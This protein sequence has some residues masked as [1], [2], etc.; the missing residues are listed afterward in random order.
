MADTTQA[1]VN[2]TYAA[3]HAYPSEP[4]SNHAVVNNTNNYQQPQSSAP[5][6]PPANEQKNEISKDEVGWFFVEQ[7]YTT[8]SR[9]PKKLHLFY[10]RRSQFVFGTEAE[11]VPVAVGQKVCISSVCPCLLVLANT[12]VCLLPQAIA[13][14]IKQL[15][16]HDCKVR[17]LNVDTQSSFENILVSVIGEISNGSEPSRKFVQTFVL[18]EQPNGYY[19]LNDIFRYLS[20][21]DEEFIVDETAPAD[22]T[23][24]QQEVPVEATAQ[25]QAEPAE[26]AVQAQTETQAAAPQVD[27]KLEQAAT[28]AAEQAQEPAPQANGTTA[29]EEKPATPAAAPAP[30]VPAVP[31]EPEAAK[32]EKPKSP[33]PT[34]ADAPTK[35][36]TAPAPEKEN[37]QPP[38]PAVPK[39]WANV[40]SNRAGSAQAPVP[41]PV[42]PVAPPKPAPAPSTTTQQ[43]QP[44][45]QPQQA[46]AQAQAQPQPSAAPST[47]P[48]PE[49]APSQPS[50]NDG[51]GWQT[52]GH[53]NKRQSRAGDDQNVFAYIKNVTEKVDAAL[54][55]Q[56][57]SRFGK[58]K[59]FDV[60]RQKVCCFPIRR[61][62]ELELTLECRTAPS[63]SLLNQPVTLPLSPQTL[64]R[65][66]PN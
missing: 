8:M 55:K 46:Q 65:S 33:E 30:A 49:S 24:A 39:T 43:P 7:Y 15:D 18:A 62:R 22:A 54:L 52:A 64:T 4:Y 59:Y 28:P 42:I 5:A 37:V 27:E 61:A 16:F 20:D 51:S 36:T 21:E 26:P 48:A 6:N 38:K 2:G 23:A 13:E 57:L 56:T 47:T 12:D 31:A 17:V 10:S 41:T 66:E 9:S 58:L 44:Q 53:D 3:H 60:S 25:A 14:K 50:S 32:P 1:T 29:Q 63:S 34:P 19:V 40:A 45:P 11:T 35:A